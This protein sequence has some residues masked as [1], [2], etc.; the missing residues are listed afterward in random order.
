MCNAFQ[1][2]PRAM[3]VY[4]EH[5]AMPLLQPVHFKYGSRLSHNRHL[6]LLYSS[7]LAKKQNAASLRSEI[8]LNTIDVVNVLLN[9]FL[10]ALLT[11]SVCITFHYVA[12]ISLYNLCSK[13]YPPECWPKSLAHMSLVGRE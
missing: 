6:F 7:H 10:C 5:P 13:L 9:G 4:N 11:L 12:T 3:Q 8:E 1:M 2:D